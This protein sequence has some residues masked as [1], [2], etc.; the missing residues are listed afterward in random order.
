MDE[1]RRGERGVRGEQTERIFAVGDVHGSCNRLE[2][3]LERLP[4][5]AGR[6][7]LVFL[8]DYIDRGGQSRK[9]IDLVCRLQDEGRVIALLGNHEHLLLEY[10]RTGGAQLLSGL[11][12]QGVEASLESY[13]C[14]DLRDLRSLSFLPERHRRF[15]FSL[16]LYWETEDY[17]FVHAGVVP[18]LALARHTAAQVCETREL[19][20]G[21][22]LLVKTVVFGHTPFLTPLVTEKRIGIDTGAA[23]GNMLTAVE[24]P[25]R[26]FYHA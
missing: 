7:T 22:E 3:L 10:H 17:V 1:G 21:S 26:V 2:R 25:G 5:R 23:Y 4:Y 16:P 15:L 9:V 14:R 20:G 18:G 11:R 8:G 24:L 6:D 12:R 13:G 19:E